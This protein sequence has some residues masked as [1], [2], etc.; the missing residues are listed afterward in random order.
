M[1]MKRERNAHDMT[2][3]LFKIGILIFL[4]FGQFKS[5]NLFHMDLCGWVKIL[6]TPHKLLRKTSVFSP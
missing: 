5:V 3:N 6:D 2:R 4:P 1:S